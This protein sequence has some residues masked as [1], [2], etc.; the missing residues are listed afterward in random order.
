MST[1]KVEYVFSLSG[2]SLET[3]MDYQLTLSVKDVSSGLE[4]KAMV[5]INVMRSMLGASIQPSTMQLVKTGRTILLDGR[6]SYDP[7]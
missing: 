3:G 2:Y 7:R 4:S 5:E 6:S 1:S